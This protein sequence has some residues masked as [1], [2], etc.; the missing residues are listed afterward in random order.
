MEAVIDTNLIIEL[1]A[2]LAGDSPEKASSE[3]I[4]IGPDLIKPLY[5]LHFSQEGDAH[6]QIYRIFAAIGDEVNV[7]EGVD[8]IQKEIIK[9]MK[10]GAKKSRQWA[11][12]EV[13]TISVSALTRWGLEVPPVSDQ[14]VHSCHVCGNKITEERI[15]VCGL[16]KC[17]NAVCREHSHVIE[18]RFGQFDGSGGAWFC[19]KDHHEHAVR[20]HTDWN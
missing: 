20:N 8:G 16:H 5:R 17:D 14:Q 2:K 19:S 4:G 6:T 15:M 12:E 13:Y 11:A 10:S 3:L 7:A 1:V 9:A 18:T